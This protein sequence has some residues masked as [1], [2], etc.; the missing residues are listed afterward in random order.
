MEVGGDL[1]L[2][3]FLPE[4]FTDP[5]RLGVGEIDLDITAPNV[6]PSVETIVSTTLDINPAVSTTIIAHLLAD[7]TPIATSFA[8]NNEELNA[9]QGRLTVRHV[10]AAG[11][12][13]IDLF[14]AS[15]NRVLGTA[16][17]VENGDEGEVDLGARQYQ[18]AISPAGGDPIL[19]PV[20]FPLRN[21]RNVIIYAIGSPTEGTFTAIGEELDIRRD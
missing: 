1:L 8:N 5:L 11:P 15:G 19:G 12:V 16:T 2:E 3:D 21:G 6:D 10:A 18:I 13:D 20:R 4:T 9:F 7:G 14:N 17:N